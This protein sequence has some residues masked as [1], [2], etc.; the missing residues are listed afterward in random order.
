MPL[1][2]LHPADRCRSLHRRYKDLEFERNRQIDRRQEA[3]RRIQRLNE[4]FMS[5]PDSTAGDRIAARQGDA[6]ADFEKAIQIIKLLEQQLE[7]LENDYFLSGCE[8]ILGR[9]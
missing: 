4:D 2:S 9:I 1:K 8:D 5:A 6:I 7:D 3:E